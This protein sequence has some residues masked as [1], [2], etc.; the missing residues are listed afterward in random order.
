MSE[1]LFDL[2][3]KVAIVTGASRGLGQ[4]FS[5]A[6]AG[7][8]ADLVI[9][10]RN[11]TSLEPFRREIESTGRK[12]LPVA[13]DVLDYRSIQTMVERALDAYGRIDI[14][15]NNAGVLRD[16]L[17]V[18]VKEGELVRQMPEA[19]FDLVISVNLKGVFNCTQAVSPVMIKQGGGVILNA[20]SIVGLDGNFGQTN[21]VASKAGV[22]GVTK[23]WA[24]ELGRYG[25]RV[26]AVA[27][28][29]TATEILVSMPERVLDGMRART[30]LG[31]L[32]EPLDIANAYLFLASDEASFITGTV[33]R[34]DGGIVVG[35]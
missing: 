21:Y 9:T 31:R 24:R 17:L 19:D 20:T 25:I 2:S 34:V 6:L 13:L 15:V 32:G 16:G 26:N 23:V 7:A 12:A 14:L 3:G 22:I 28:G 18:K 11:P 33:L 27:P 4:Y 10:S 8:G 5:R 30:P 1:N 35:T 29:F